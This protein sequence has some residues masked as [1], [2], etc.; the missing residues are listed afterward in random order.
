VNETRLELETSDGVRIVAHR[1]LPHRRSSGT[2]AVVTHGFAASASE[3]RVREI[4]DALAGAGHAVLT[5]DSRGHGESGGEATL[6]TDEALDVAAVVEAAGDD[7]PVL[8][9][10]SAGAI[11][12]LR[13]A[14]EHAPSQ[15]VAGVVIV[16][17]PARWTLPR[18][19]RGV[20]SAL[21]TQ[22]PLGRWAARR[23]VKVRIARPKPRPAPPIELLPAGL[24]APDR[25]DVSAEARAAVAAIHAMP[26]A[27]RETLALR[28]I[29]GLSGPEIALVTGLTPESVRV[30]LHRGF[31]LLR[32]RLGVTP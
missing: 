28:L 12:V 25:P 30:N 26:E 5:Y 21:M 14:V 31:R 16:S 15:R 23:Y 18:N 7:A 3:E 8:V 11:G 20:L 32:E 19:A 6:G 24:T 4:A 17:C 2:T 1:R 27:Y 22:T 29:E 9:G 13:Y 10:A